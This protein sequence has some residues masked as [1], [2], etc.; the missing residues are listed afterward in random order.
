MSSSTR[1]VFGG[2]YT[3]YTNVIDYVTIAS[4]GNAQDFGDLLANSSGMGGT[5]N[6]IRGVFT[7]GYAPSVQNVI[8]F[9]TIASTGNSQVFGDLSRNWAYDCTV[10][11]AHGGI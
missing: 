8:Q 3:P 10:S 11:D 2:G 1:A 5:S 6:K 4:T 7:G 9:I